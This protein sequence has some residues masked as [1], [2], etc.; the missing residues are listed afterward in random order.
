[1]LVTFLSKR[2]IT[3]SNWLLFSGRVSGF[4]NTVIKVLFGSPSIV[5][6][7]DTEVNEIYFFSNSFC[8]DL[9]N[10]LNKLCLTLGLISL[11][12]S[13]IILTSKSKFSSIFLVI[14]LKRRSS[15][16]SIQFLLCYLLILSSLKSFCFFSFL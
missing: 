12:F 4:S 15:S 11:G 5:F 8:K 6:V 16:S 9:Q 7:F 3:K 2:V 14:K 1:M 10:F 13:R